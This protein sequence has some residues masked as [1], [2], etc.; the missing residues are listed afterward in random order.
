MSETEKVDNLFLI[1]NTLD[2]ILFEQERETT[3]YVRLACEFHSLLY[4]SMVEALRGTANLA[5]TGHPKDKKRSVMYQRGDMVWK[6]IHKENL[7]GCKL[8]WRFSEAVECEA[9]EIK[10]N[11]EHYL[12]DNYLKSF[13]DLLA[14]I[15]T[16]C[17]MGHYVMSQVI[18]V[19]DSE[20]KSLEWL[21]E[22]IRNE[23]EHFIPKLYLT[24]KNDLI[25]ASKICN[26]L[27]IQ[28]LFHS[29]N[30]LIY[31]THRAETLVQN[32]DICKK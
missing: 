7:T 10:E 20:M 19:S 12:F 2:H 9:P 31:N 30:V 22:R 1:E 17:Y 23:Y 24:Y 3:S 6:E 27:S 21:H 29:G 18:H 32:L 28:L 26:K 14:M 13:F 11:G 16:E 4:R 15:Q 8:A 5:I 25:N